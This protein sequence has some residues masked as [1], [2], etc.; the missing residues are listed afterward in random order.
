MK[1]AL[2]VLALAAGSALAQAPY[3]SKPV[4]VITQFTPG[5]PGDVLTRGVTQVIGQSM[6]QPFVIENRPGAEGLIAAEACV[7]SAP[8]GYTLCSADS[9]TVSMA[10]ALHTKLAYDPGRDLAPIVHFGFLT[11]FVLTQPSL[12]VNS[13]KELFE[14]ARTKPNSVTWGS[15]GPA[16]SPHLYMEWLKKERGIGFLNVPYK[17]APFAYQGLQ[18]GEIQVAV[19]ATGPSLAHVKSGKLK[20]IALV[21]PSRSARMPDVPT[22]E[23]AGLPVKISTWFGLFA[24][25]GAPRDAIQRVNAE[26]VKGFYGNAALK[27]KFLVAQGY[28]LSSPAGGTPEAFAAFLRE[29]REAQAHVVKVTGARVDH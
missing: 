13:L 7:K 8:D 15:W 24:P 6:G 26:V 16:S 17:S 11:S 28:D 10:P 20:A 29:D 12:G 18:A 9:F 23:E 3:P 2:A 27:D 21:S 25:A 5:G 14:L 19:F 4:R 22:L 1:T